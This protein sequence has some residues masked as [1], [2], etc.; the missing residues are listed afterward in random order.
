MPPNF[1]GRGQSHVSLRGN[2]FCGVFQELF[3][4]ADILI[5][6]LR[7][8]PTDLKEKPACIWP[9]SL[10]FLFVAV[11]LVS[12]LQAIS[13]CF[14]PFFVWN[15]RFEEK[16]KGLWGKRRRNGF[17]FA[18]KINGV[19]CCLPRQ[20]LRRKVGWML[21]NSKT[22]EKC[23]PFHLHDEWSSVR[24]DCLLFECLSLFVWS[25]LRCLRSVFEGICKAGSVHLILVHRD[26]NYCFYLQNHAKRQ[27]RRG[28]IEPRRCTGEIECWELPRLCWKRTSLFTTWWKCVLMA[29]KNSRSGPPGGT[30]I[31][32][33]SS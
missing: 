6:D 5:I 9:L 22:F 23:A 13:L 33:K 17:V 8:G 20:S 28:W 16:N 11:S 12:L 25:L 29:R 14:T 15:W 4:N 1:D 30:A 3:F 10:L 26:L 31:L 21:M 27:G 24:F 18:R 2:Y 19:V 7:I 32:S